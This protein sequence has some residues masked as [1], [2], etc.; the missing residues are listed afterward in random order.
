MTV[1][2]IDPHYLLVPMEALEVL[3]QQ[4]QYTEE[5]PAALTRLLPAARPVR[6][7]SHATVLL[8]SDPTHP[9]VTARLV[10]GDRLISIPHPQCGERLI[11]AVAAVDELR[12]AGS[13]EAAQTHVSVSRYLLSQTYALLDA[14]RSADAG[15]LREELG[16]L[17]LQVLFQARIAQDAPRRPFA[18]DDVADTL[19]RKLGN[20][21]RG[22]LAGNSPL[23]QEQ[24]AQWEKGKKA[25]KR[26]GS[27]MHDLFHGQPAL[28][29][30]QKVIERAV[31]AGLPMDLVPATLTSVVVS[32]DI[33]SEGELRAAVLEFM[34][35]VR[36]AEDTIAA[37]RRAPD[38]TEEPDRTAL[39][40]ITEREWRM[41]WPS[42]GAHTQS[43]V[44]VAKPRDDA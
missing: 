32:P 38:A 39:G 7:G 36:R 30:A 5:I 33:D 21:R 12:T 18:I 22:V 25:D 4:V 2:L 31:R 29:L 3:R 28:A 27:V 20:R 11:D 14:L 35:S 10:A 24:V 23:F 19:I 34:D 43:G 44:R 1:V 37:R 8:S 17:L 40:G 13:W 9:A 41:C 42:V 16:A 26:A 15:Q 6:A